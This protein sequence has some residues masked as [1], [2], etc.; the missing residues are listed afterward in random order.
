MDIDSNDDAGIAGG[1]LLHTKRY[2]A[3]GWL[4][5]RQSASTWTSLSPRAL[6]NRRNGSG[7]KLMRRRVGEGSVEGS[8]RG[9]AALAVTIDV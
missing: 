5:S 1:D 6:Q 9:A 4:P 8:D 7:T 2:G 3:Q